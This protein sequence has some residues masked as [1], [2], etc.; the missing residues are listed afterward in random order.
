M[1]RERWSSRTVFIL[2][3][4][5]SAVGL[6]NAWRFPGQAFNNGGGAFLI[7]Y[8]VALITA[9]IPLLILENA[10]GKK[11]QGGAPTA[12]GKCGK[13]GEALG[14]WALATSFV[15]VAYYTVVMAWVIDYIWYSLTVAWKDV[16]AINFFL[17]NVL[18]LT[19]DPGTLGGFSI[20]VLIG[21]VLAWLFVYYC[22]R[23]GVKSVSKVIVWTVPI[24]VIF[25]IILVIRAVTLEGA[26]TGLSYYLTPDWAALLD[27]GVWASAYGQVFFSLTQLST[28]KP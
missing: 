7:P 14:W 11:F 6:G 26:V 1:S 22:I 27:P 5:G 19:N 15:I 25:M 9:G 8:F 10:I 17:N 2:A 16:G 21:L 23:N 28:N 20:P 18:G 13:G 3:A 24:P 12:L 4:I